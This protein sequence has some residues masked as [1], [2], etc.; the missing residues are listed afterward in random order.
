MNIS[1]HDRDLCFSGQRE[2]GG[3]YRPWSPPLPSICY[4]ALLFLIC[5]GQEFL[6]SLCPQLKKYQCS[7]AGYPAPAGCN[8]KMFSLNPQV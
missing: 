5:C 4:P 1:G 2:H 8:K 3:F 6:R 7:A